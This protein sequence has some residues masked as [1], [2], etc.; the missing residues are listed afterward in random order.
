MRRFS[1][2]PPDRLCR[3][4]A[5]RISTS[6]KL[7]PCLLT[8]VLLAICPCIAAAENGKPHRK[9]KKKGL[10]EQTLNQKNLRRVLKHCDDN[11]ITFYLSGP[12]RFTRMEETTDF[13]RTAK[14]VAHKILATQLDTI[15]PDFLDR[16]R[17]TGFWVRKKAA[18]HGE[19]EPGSDQNGRAFDFDGGIR[20]GKPFIGGKTRFTRFTLEYDLRR[21][22]TRLFWIREFGPVEG[23]LEFRTGDTREIR[24]H[25]SIPAS[26]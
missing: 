19:V 17:E 16:W 22:R 8:L 24:I 12:G 13:R 3:D 14:Y 23:R 25:F 20:S 1:T 2:S 10:F 21:G 7:F 6:G 26:P 4:I 15:H 18:H 5:R 9:T 11:H